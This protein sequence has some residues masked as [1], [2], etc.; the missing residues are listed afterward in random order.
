MRTSCF[1]AYEEYRLGRKLSDGELAAIATEIGC[2]GG[3]RDTLAA[4]RKALTK[5]RLGER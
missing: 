4:L 3:K 2:T 5:Y 1:Q